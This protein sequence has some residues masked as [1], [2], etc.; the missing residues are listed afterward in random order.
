MTN[1]FRKK[2]A[3]NLYNSG[4]IQFETVTLKSGKLS[5]IYIDLR[6]LVS[7]PS[8]IE[9]VGDMMLKYLMKDLKYDVICGVPFTAIP[10]ATYLSIISKT[11]M[12]MKRSETKSYGTKKMIEGKI[13]A[14]Q[15]ALIVEDIISSG[16]S[17]METV[18]CLKEKGLLVED[19][20]VVLDREQGGY[21]SLENLG[22]RVHSLIKISELFE[23]LK[24]ENLLE[25]NKSTEILNWIHSTT[26]NIQDSVIQAY[27][28]LCSGQKETKREV[29]SYEEREKL[30]KNKIAKHLFKLI[31]EKKSNLCVAIDESDK[32]VILDIIDKVGPNS[33]MI[34]LHCDIIDN[35]DQEFID[36][37]KQLAVHHRFLVFE[38]RKFAD[39]GNTVKDQFTGGLYKISSWAD[40]INCFVISGEGIID[41][42]KSSAD[43]EK[44]ACIIVAELSSKGNLITNAYTEFAVK[45]AENHSNFVI[46]F[47]SQSRVTTDQRFIHFTPGVNLQDSNDKFDQSYITPSQAIKDRGA[48]VII[49]GRGISKSKDPAKTSKIYKEEAFTAYKELL[50]D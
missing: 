42:L 10:F 23:I 27:K 3:L 39:I 32:N 1:E 24:Q 46:G 6:I 37:L 19:V 31:S 2:L 20:V 15:R 4:C 35:F 11:P 49:V 28:R 12:L 44:N 18:I 13:V 7:Y 33:I 17:I 41:S 34:K 5:P 21:K 16:G 47:I 14:G 8:V 26:A 40:V 48:D 9:S 25:S 38:D 22:I 29:L 45:F 50:I 30:T 43:L 36:K